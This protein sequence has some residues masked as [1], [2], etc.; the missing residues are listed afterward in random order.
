MKDEPCGGIYGN[1]SAICRV[2]PTTGSQKEES[3]SEFILQSQRLLHFGMA[4]LL[5]GWTF[6]MLLSQL[7]C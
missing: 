6:Y 3:Q 1:E 2:G 7:G 4:D 5:R